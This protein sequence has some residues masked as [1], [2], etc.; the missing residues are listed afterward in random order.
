MAAV[1]LLLFLGACFLS[2][3]LAYLDAYQ[4]DQRAGPLVD[5]GMKVLIPAGL[6]GVIAAV[7]PRDGMPNTVRGT[8]VTLQ[9]VL[10][11]LAPV[12]VAADG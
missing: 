10:T 2:V 6:T 3:L 7:V 1:G 4:S 11:F 12:L 8:L 5:A 9:Y